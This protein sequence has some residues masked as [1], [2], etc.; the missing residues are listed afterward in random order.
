MASLL[1]L[2]LVALSLGTGPV[3]NGR[4]RELDVRP[5]RLEQAIT[6]DG[7][8]DEPVWQQASVLT[9]SSRYAPTDGVAADDSTEVLVWYSPG[10]IHFGIRAFAA[11]GTVNATL[12]DRDRMYNDDYIGIFLGTFND[13]RQATVFAVNPLGVQGDGIV[14]ERGAS[15]GGGFGGIV[16]GREPTDIA[17]DFVFQSKGR[18]TDYGYEV[19]IRVPFKSLRYQ[20]AATQTWGVNV[21]RKVQSRG[22]E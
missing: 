6:I 10:A 1:P 14:V 16:T 9:G 4:A 2:G 12:A 21:L 17:P 15:S 22:Y 13:G 18:L 5:T 8:L 7:H 3:H 11:P 20:S 19:E